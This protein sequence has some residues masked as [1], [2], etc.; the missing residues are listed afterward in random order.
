VI[1]QLA[2]DSLA[3]AS[4]YALV[5]L[6]VSLAFSGSGTVHLAIGQVAMAGGLT[7]S[8]LV[9]AGV[10]IAF[11]ALG[12]L[13][14]AAVLS[15][16]AERG[17]IA[18]ALGRPVLGAVLLVAMAV[19]LREVLQGIFT[20]PAYAF[21]SPAGTMHVLGGV[22]H[23]ADLVTIAVVAVTALLAAALLRSSTIGAALRVTAAAPAAAERIGVDTA[24]VRVAAFAAGGTLA[25]IAVLLGVGRFPLTAGGGV[26]LA[27]RGIAAAAAGGMRSPGRVVAAAAVIAAAEVVGGFYLG[28]GGEF[29]SDAVAV[30]LIAAA[31]RR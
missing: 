1:V 10:P 3:A 20:R 9:T 12:G 4:L 29:L 15:G 28:G 14:V 6:A 30:L 25:A 16:V 2:V 27:L 8:A 21:P 22:I 17:L 5:A 31:W 11:A 19:V 7:A 26:V 24:R 18:P 23:T 13:A